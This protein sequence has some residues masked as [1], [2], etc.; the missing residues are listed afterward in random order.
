MCGGGRHASFPLSTSKVALWQEASSLLG[1]EGLT[2]AMDVQMLSRKAQVKSLMIFNAVML[3]VLFVHLQDR[4][5]SKV[6]LWQKASSREGDEGL[7]GAMEVQRLIR[8]VQ[9]KSFMFFYVAMI[10]VLHVFF[11]ES[12]MQAMMSVLHT[13]ELYGFLS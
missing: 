12:S 2:G 5:F 1:D 13:E 8:K 7:T 6:A 4:Y 11:G 9:V 10:S 3:S